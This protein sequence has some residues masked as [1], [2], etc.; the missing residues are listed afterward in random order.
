MW[1]PIR[2]YLPLDNN[3]IKSWYF[4]KLRLLQLIKTA[5]P[6]WED[7]KPFLEKITSSIGDLTQVEIYILTKKVI[8]SK[9]IFSWSLRFYLTFFVTI[10]CWFLY[11][12]KH[13]CR[14]FSQSQNMYVFLNFFHLY[15]YVILF[16]GHLLF[17][18]DN[19]L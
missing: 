2:Q 3:I 7:R 14:I 11:V 1:K 18:I 12:Y 4:F 6:S 13:C 9:N 5:R 15:M 16:Y 10:I 19:V 17:R 8:F